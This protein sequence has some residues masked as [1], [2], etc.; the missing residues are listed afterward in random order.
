[1]SATLSLT[2]LLDNKR[3]FPETPPIISI[4][5][6]QHSL[7]I[8]FS[9]RTNP[10]YVNEAVKKVLKIHRRLPEGGILIFLTGQREIE[11]VISKLSAVGK[12]NRRK[13]ETQPRNN[14]KGGQ[15]ESL[16]ARE[17]KSSHLGESAL[18][19]VLQEMSRSTISSL[20]SRTGMKIQRQAI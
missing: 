4:P 1:M 13:E 18:A 10:D 19:H 11:Y 12:K 9:R 20:V 8:H 15:L 17:G 2:S 16:G 5:A 6:R 7:T 3:L 14:R